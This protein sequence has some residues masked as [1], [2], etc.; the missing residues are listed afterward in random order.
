MPMRAM[1]LEQIERALTLHERPLP[2][3]A[4]G[5]IRI[6]IEACALCRTDLH[7]V[8]GELADA[9]LPLVPGH[10][11][12][13]TVDAASAGRGSAAPAA[14]VGT[15][16]AVARTCVAMR[17]SPAI[18]GMAGSPTRA[19]P[20]RAMP[21]RCLPRTPRSRWPRSCAVR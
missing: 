9:A 6:A 14:H 13:G 10:Q 3:P 2:V 20:T 17:A 12:A 21:C 1:V 19:S 18:T 8:D 16:R 11:I 7:I 4:P 15:A 5:E